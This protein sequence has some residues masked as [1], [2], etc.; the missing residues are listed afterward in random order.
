MRFLGRVA[1]E[2]RRVSPHLLEFTQSSMLRENPSQ[3]IHGR[4]RFLPIPVDLISVI[5]PV[6]AVLSGLLDHVN[7]YAL[8]YVGVTGEAFWP[9]AKRAIGLAGRRKG[10]RLLDCKLRVMKTSSRRPAQPFL[11]NRHLDQASVDAF[12]YDD[13]TSNS[14]HWLFVRR[15][16][17]RCSESCTSRCVA[18]WRR[19]ILCSA[20]LCW[21]ARRCVS[22]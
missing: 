13:S 22:P 21:R 2:A 15:S 18:V 19:S 6:I 3:I 8:I 11:V 16:C 14:S 7:G 1:I 20:R 4:S 5:A 12:L 17:S 9:S 10:S